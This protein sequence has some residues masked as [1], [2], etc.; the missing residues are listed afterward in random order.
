MAAEGAQVL[1]CGR[2]ARPAE[3]ADNVIWQTADVSHKADVDGLK[4]VVQEKLGGLDV[5]VNNAGI[6]VEKTV[7]ESTDADWD[8]VIGINARAPFMLCRA[9]IPL[10]VAGG[11][12]SI[13]NIGSI[14]GHHADPSMALYNA[15]KAFVHGLTRSVAVDHGAE[16]IRCNAICPG[17]IMTGMADAAFAMAEDPARLKKMRW[18]AMLSAGSASLRILP[19]RR[20]GLR[21]M[22]QL[23]SPARQ[24]PLMAGLSLPR[25]SA[26]ACSDRAVLIGL[27][28]SFMLR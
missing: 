17:W 19:A 24:S 14:S 25:L 5:L 15:S 9:L 16:G 12:G 18:P 2:G 13:V 10:M 1:T 22:M 6:Q 4:Q 27:V 21:R 28:S 3:L 26:P 23:S 8:D 7:T 20:S 11:G